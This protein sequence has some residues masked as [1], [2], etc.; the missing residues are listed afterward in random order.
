MSKTI[1]LKVGIL[2]TRG[3]PN[4][5]GGF[6]QCAEY[7]AA[8]LVSKGHRVWV[9]NSHDHEYQGKEWNGVEIIHCYDP[10]HK[11]G[12]PG[13]F[14]YD[15][16]CINDAR[17]RNYDVLLQLGYTSNSIWYR[18]WP[19]YCS[20][21]VNMDGLEWKRSKYSRQAQKFLRVAE[22]WAAQRGDVLI[23]D[24]V[25]IQQ[26]LKDTYQKDS[27][28]IPYGAEIF[29]NPRAEV[30]SKY[31]MQPFGYDMLIARMEP[32]NNIE[33][34]I[35][36]HSASGTDKPL[37]IVGK[38]TNEFGSYLLKNYGKTAGIHFLGAI[39]DAEII[40]N[41]RYY[42]R[43]YFHGHSVGGTNP[44]LLEAMGCNALIVAH[45]NPFNQAVLGD[46]AFYFNNEG[47]L[48]EIIKNFTSRPVYE[49]KM[50][51]NIEKIRTRYNWPNIVD[52]YEA[53]LIESVGR[54]KKI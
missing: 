4:R 34:I 33:A 44:S 47:D 50:T 10:E 14:I 30:L 54:R 5:Y 53:V 38:T 13:Q 7:L 35:R 18:L 8:G 1:S 24:S 17:K 21:V 41:L 46:D 49:S 45:A 43:L 52:E 3:I 20:N 28:F 15:L 27:F 51:N 22:K 42:S 16:N 36:G 32:E 26:Y 19:K 2:G 9:Y 29:D 6:E 11:I 12:T 48:S 40:N 25:G 37:L 39:Y 31:G 23:A